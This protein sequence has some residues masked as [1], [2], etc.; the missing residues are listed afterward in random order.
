M[1]IWSPWSKRKL[2]IMDLE[3]RVIYCQ[4]SLES[5]D[6]P[7]PH[8]VLA[9]IFTD[10]N[11]K[12]QI[13]FSHQFFTPNPFVLAPIPVGTKLHHSKNFLHEFLISNWMTYLEPQSS[14]LQW[15][16][17]QLVFLH[18]SERGMEKAERDSK[19]S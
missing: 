2:N 17:G 10:G 8:R 5:M 14:F 1:K 16:I 9:L 13:S 3:T 7:K 15:A 18:I 4:L 11:H 12:S 19:N 6:P